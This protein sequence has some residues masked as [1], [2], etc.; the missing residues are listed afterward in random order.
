MY[1]TDGPEAM[2]SVAEIEFINGIGA[3]AASGLF[4]DPKVGA[5]IVGSVDLRL[6]DE[7]EGILR[8]HVQA[9]GA[10]YRGV[11]W[12][13]IHYDEDERILETGVGAPHLLLDKTFRAGFKWLQPLFSA[14]ATR[15][16]RLDT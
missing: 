9:G 14:I 16:Y 12:A 8:A 4:G 6:G 2:K 11:R 7:V 10:R 13:G 5:G 1:R 15:V 3:M